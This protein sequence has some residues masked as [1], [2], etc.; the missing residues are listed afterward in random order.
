M[1]TRAK[2]T[3]AGS[4]AFCGFTIWGVHYLQRYEKELMRAGVHRE[5]ERQQR[6]MQQL[7][8]KEELDAQQALHEQLIKSQSVTATTGV[9][10]DSQ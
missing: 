4:F 8:N 1:S 5:E 9:A 7:A 6:K 10:D 2:I 3:L